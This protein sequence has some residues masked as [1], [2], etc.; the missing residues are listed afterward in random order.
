MTLETLIAAKEAEIAKTEAENEKMHAYESQIKNWLSYA[1]SRVN[2]ALSLGIA[3]VDIVD[4]LHESIGS[5]W[6]SE[7]PND[8]GLIQ[9]A[10]VNVTEI[11][12][13]AT[14]EATEADIILIAL[15]NRYIKGI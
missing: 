4:S 12:A 3:P 8:K 1:M 7:S 15:R 11:F 14:D 10:F 5:K 6:V 13:S 2:K 9:K